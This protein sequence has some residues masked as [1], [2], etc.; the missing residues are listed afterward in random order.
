MTQ[1]VVNHMKIMFYISMTMLLFGCVN[2]YEP[3]SKSY[4]G[5]D[6][7]NKAV[8]KTHYGVSLRKVD[9]ERFEIFVVIPNSFN[10]DK[11][12]T[13]IL[14]NKAVEL[15]DDAFELRVENSE[16]HGVIGADLPNE[17]LTISQKA[18]LKCATLRH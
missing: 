7:E 17:W 1:N 10:R 6:I 2:F 13:E 18:V 12:F 9:N 4:F 3:A 16:L 8:A 15:C 14:V 11:I 5:G